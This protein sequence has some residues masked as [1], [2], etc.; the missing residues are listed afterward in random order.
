MKSQIVADRA[1]GMDNPDYLDRVVDGEVV[2]ALASSPAVL[3]E[4]P[5]GCGKTW[6]GQHFSRSEVMLDGTEAQRMAA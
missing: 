4:G 6:T 2:E 3:I 1:D 5:R